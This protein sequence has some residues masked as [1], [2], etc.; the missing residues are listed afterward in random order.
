MKMIIEK[1]WL[2]VI[3]THCVIA[4]DLIRN[5]K[6]IDAYS[7]ISGIVQMTREKVESQEI[8]GAGT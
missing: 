5:G 3:L 2:D 8:K 7:Q 6:I 1:E 4:Q